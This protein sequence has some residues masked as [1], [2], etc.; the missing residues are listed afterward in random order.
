MSEVF[1]REEKLLAEG[2]MQI[3]DAVA[4]SGICRS[5]LYVAMANG[6]LPFVQHGARRLIPRQ[7]LRDYLARR[8][9]GTS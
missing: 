6:E 2:T 9:V 8:L 4:W 5:K 7:A 1:R 3:A